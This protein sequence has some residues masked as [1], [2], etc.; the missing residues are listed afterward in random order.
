MS[1]SIKDIEKFMRLEKAYSAP[2]CNTRHRLVHH[3]DLATGLSVMIG[4][5]V[6]VVMIDTWTLRAVIDTLDGA[7]WSVPLA[8]LKMETGH[9]FPNTGAQRSWCNC[10]PAVGL[11]NWRT[12]V[13]E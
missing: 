4:Q 6:A 12:G 3:V 10:C 8:A 2:K 9:D 1:L 13:Y 7:Q 11:F 5:V